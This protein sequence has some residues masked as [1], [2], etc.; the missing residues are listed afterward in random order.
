MPNDDTMQIRRIIAARAVAVN[1]GDVDGI[2]ADV[3]DDVVIYELVP[4]LRSRGVDASR[5]R[6][7]EWLGTY[8]D[9]PHW[10]DGKI[11]IVADG[12]VAFSHSLNHVTGL[13]KSGAQV[14]MWFRTTLGWRRRDGRWRIVHD[15]NSVP[16]D[17]KTGKGRLDLEPE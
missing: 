2:V 7:V 15:H 16:F 17:P 3:D 6:A 1:A 12:D 5:R 4:P 10:E 11:E 14:D 8:K 13:A 9:G